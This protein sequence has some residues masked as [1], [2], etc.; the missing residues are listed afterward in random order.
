MPPNERRDSIVKAR[1]TPQ[2]MREFDQ[3]SHDLCLNES[4]LIRAGTAALM[5]RRRRQP[6]K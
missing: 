3:L 4:E 1:L 6:A 5:E 2:E